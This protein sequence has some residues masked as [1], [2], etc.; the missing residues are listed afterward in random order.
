MSKNRRGCVKGNLR[1]LIITK[2]GKKKGVAKWETVDAIQ[3]GFHQGTKYWDRVKLQIKGIV[4][5][6]DEEVK[7]RGE[8]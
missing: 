1:E 3:S 5:T 4:G 6:A 2:V 8:C 7:N